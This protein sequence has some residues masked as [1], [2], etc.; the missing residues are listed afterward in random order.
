[1]SSPLP[2]DRWESLVAEYGSPLYVYE[3][4][5]VRAAHAELAASLPDGAGLLYSLKANPHPA[6]VAE[7][8]RLGCGAEVS[9]HSELV[10]ALAAG[11]DPGLVSYTGPGRS[12]AETVA[13]VEAGARLFSV[14]SADQYATLARAAARCGAAVEAVLRVNPD[15]APQAPGLA[16]TGVASQFGIDEHLL[17]SRPERYRSA[18]GCEIVG[19]HFYL[20][21]NVPDPDGLARQFT[22]SLASAAR[23][24]AALGIRPR[25][26]NLGGGF[27]SGYARAE[28][29]VG[30]AAVGPA[31]ERAL[32]ACFPARDARPRLLF[33]SGRRLV[34][35]SGVLVARVVDVKESKGRRFA[36]LDSGINHLGGMTALGRLPRMQA[37]VAGD[38]AARPLEGAVP[39]DVVGPLCTPLDSWARGQRLAVEAG[40]LVTVPQ[41]GA[42]GLTASLLAFLGRACPTELVTDRGAVVDASALVYTRVAVGPAAGPSSPD[43][44]NASRVAGSSSA[45]ASAK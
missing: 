44:S 19:L 24:C 41:V 13:A 17:T 15:R 21:S 36:V 28:P 16:M 45:P 40:D 11:I 31:V 39:V 33:E 8:G 42:Y 1:M 43:A 23:I 27:P 4:E 22:D 20:G 26:L 29:A 25:I 7:L 12:E 2:A 3:L 35:R 32:H 10:T 38:A 14:D 37:A 34:G 30:L 18:P 6:L 9:S 5:E